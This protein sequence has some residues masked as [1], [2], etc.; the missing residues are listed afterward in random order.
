MG[1]KQK[2]REKE[3]YCKSK[4]DVYILIFPPKTSDSKYTFK[5]GKSYIH[6]IS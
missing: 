3:T 6:E 2:G 5:L 1:K 4:N